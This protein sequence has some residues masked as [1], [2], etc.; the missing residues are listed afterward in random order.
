MT[1]AQIQLEHMFNKWNPLVIPFEMVFFEIVGLQLKILLLRLAI[2]R[3]FLKDSDTLPYLL[4][5]GYVFWV[6]LRVLTL[7]EWED[8]H[9]ESSF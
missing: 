4:V 9:F 5:S 8:S 3:N 1:T 6:L 2:L 7:Y